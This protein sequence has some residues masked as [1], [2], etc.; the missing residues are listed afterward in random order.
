MLTTFLD[1]IKAGAQKGATLT[2]RV[3]REANA[4]LFGLVVIVRSETL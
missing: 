3:D 4:G 2:Q 1:A